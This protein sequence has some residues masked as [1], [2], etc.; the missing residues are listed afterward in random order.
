MKCLKCC[1][2][3]PQLSSPVKEFSKSVNVGRSFD[4]NFVDY[5]YFF[6]PP[7]MSRNTDVTVTYPLRLNDR[8]LQY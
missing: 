5:M 3:S 4:R 2:I 8:V 6:V 7:Y 1:G